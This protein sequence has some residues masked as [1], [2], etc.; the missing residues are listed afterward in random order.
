MTEAKPTTPRIL[1]P[2]W[3]WWI[4]GVVGAVAMM[5]SGLSFVYAGV[6]TSLLRATTIAGQPVGGLDSLTATHLLEQRWSAFTANAFSFRAS[7]ATFQISVTDTVASD[8]EVVLGVASLDIPASVNRALAFGRRGDFW[9]KLRERTSAWLGRRHEFAVADLNRTLLAEQL[10]T[11]LAAKEQPATNAGIAIDAG[12]NVSTTPS[13]PGVTF[14]YAQAEFQARDRF[15][16]LDPTPITIA[17]IP[18]QPVIPSSP[19]LQTAAA[20]GVSY[21]LDRAPYTLTYGEKS[22]TIDRDHTAALAGFFLNNGQ[23]VVGFDTVKTSTYLETAAK[24]IN[25]T[26]Q[27]AKFS[28]VAGKVKEFQPSVVG[29]K[30][31]ALATVAAMNQSLLAAQQVPVAIVTSTEQPLTDTVDTNTLGISELVAEATTNFKGSPTNRRFN[32]GFGAQLLNGLMIQPGEEF[33]LVQALGK[34]DAAHGWKPELVIKGTRITPEFGGGLCQV[35][36]TMFRTALNAGLPITERHNHS[37]RISYYEPPVGLDATIYEPKPDLRFKNDYD[38]PLLIQT[39]VEGNNLTFRF[40]GTKDGRTVDLPTPRVYNQTKIP[41][42]QT[43]MVDTLKPGEKKCQAPGHPGA[44]ATATYTVT[45]ADGTK[46]TQ[47]FQS[48]YRALG[49]VC[50]VGKPAAKPPAAATNTAAPTNS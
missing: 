28:V 15:A 38:R 47:V 29:V 22:W 16:R 26:A 20:T 43:I 19:T 11:A 8:D 17:T 49:V 2:R 4:I 40:Y 33:S 3:A 13:A 50:Q 7:D 37:L 36:T 39:Q 10:H 44:D 41:A 27:N 18:A 24:D 45:K 9:Q 46:V 25:V 23:P 42:T 14:G 31:D 34:I 48:H 12:Q 35:A 6:G 21:L 1:W 5:A 32:L 30:V